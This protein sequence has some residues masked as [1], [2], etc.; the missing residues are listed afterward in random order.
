MKFLDFIFDESSD[1][2]DFRKIIDQRDK[3]ML[4]KVRELS[5]VASRVTSKYKRKKNA[6]L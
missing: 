4:E 5:E 6:D 3:E 2:D 1:K